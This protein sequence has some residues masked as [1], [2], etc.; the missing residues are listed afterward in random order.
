MP[1]N[2]LEGLKALGEQLR[3]QIG[4]ELDLDVLRRQE[5]ARP[6][7]ELLAELD[8][9][10]GLETVKEQ[11]PQI[12]HLFATEVRKGHGLEAAQVLL[13]HSKSDVTQVYAE[14]N[15]SLAVAVAAQI[16]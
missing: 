14:R 12:R 15:L 6:L 8:A 11:S 2:P 4:E 9:L 10:P 16:G 1:T 13:G 7:E 5:P 3:N